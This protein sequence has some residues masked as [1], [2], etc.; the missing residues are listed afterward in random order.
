VRA[1]ELFAD[2]SSVCNIDLAPAQYVN[3][4]AYLPEQVVP[5]AL[6]FLLRGQPG[7]FA[8]EAEAR[9]AC[10]IVREDDGLSG[11]PS[12]RV[13]NARL[14]MAFVSARYYGFPSRKLD[15][16]GVTGTNGKG[17]TAH[18]IQQILLTAGVQTGLIGSMTGPPTTPEAPELHRRLA[19]IVAG[20]GRA[21]ALEVSSHALA[22]HRVAGVRF[23]VAVL[24]Q[25][26]RDHLDFHQTLTRYRA[27]KALLFSSRYTSSS[28]VNSDDDLGLALLARN[29]TKITGYCLADARDLCAGSAGSS[30]SWGGVSMVTRLPGLHNVANCLAAATTARELGVK[31]DIIRRALREAPSLPGRFE[32]IEAGQPFGIIVDYAHTP[33]ALDGLLRTARMGYRRLVLVFGCQGERDRGKRPI[34]GAIAAAG[35]DGVIVTSDDS[36]TEDPLDVIEEIRMGFPLPERHVLIEPNR[37]QAIRTAISWAS[38]EDVV[39]VAGRGNEPTLKR[40]GSTE[41]FDDRVVAGEEAKRLLLHRS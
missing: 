23:R 29:S 34:M 9:G 41:P 26:D 1:D 15:V 33:G 3:G 6:F 18:L 38:P 27:T 36:E 10:A 2:L 39:V 24:T 12:I 8:C 35:A 32:R 20:G 14:A 31:V 22:W 4:L 21:V 37:R 28:V 7:G 16:I 11:I 30:W 25:V 17:T 5:G 13:H 19:K 40:P